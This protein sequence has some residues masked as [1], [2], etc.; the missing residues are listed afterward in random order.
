MSQRIDQMV[1]FQKL[2][3]PDIKYPVDEETCKPFFEMLA[4][5]ASPENLH[6]DGEISPAQARRK[7]ADIEKIWADLEAIQG[8]KQ[9]S[10]EF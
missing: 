1:S 7:L 9:Q 6:C 2:F 10:M 4:A 3:N 8:K 5:E